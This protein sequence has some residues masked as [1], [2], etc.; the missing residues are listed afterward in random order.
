ME[1]LRLRKVLQLVKGSS[2]L[3]DA[4]GHVLKTTQAVYGHRQTCGSGLS[5]ATLRANNYQTP[6]VHVWQHT[7][8]LFLAGGLPL[9]HPS[10][11]IGN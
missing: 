2:E 3:L 9:S 10:H 5:V 4:T 8:A 7:R 11:I 6:T 1:K